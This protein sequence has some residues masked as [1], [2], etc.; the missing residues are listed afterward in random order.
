MVVH[1]P[2]DLMEGDVAAVAQSNENH[3][4]RLI[5]IEHHEPVTL[6]LMSIAA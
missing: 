4:L 3:Q 6:T 1:L 2:S 5:D